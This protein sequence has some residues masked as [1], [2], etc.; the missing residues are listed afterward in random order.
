MKLQKLAQ[1]MTKEI[2]KI[3]VVDDDMIHLFTTK[4]MLQLTGYKGEIISFKNGEEALDGLSKIDNQNDFPEVIFLDINMP[5]LDGWGF[6]K[7]FANKV[8]LHSYTKIYLVTSSIDPADQEKVKSFP[9]V[10]V[11]I[12]KPFT[13][14]GLEQIYKD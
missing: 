1:K 8:P 10:K 3:A 14:E 5:I 2:K 6:L 4:K 7:N 11:F 12:T 13:K 9:E